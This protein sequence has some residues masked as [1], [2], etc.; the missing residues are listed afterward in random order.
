MKNT[1]N[2]DKFDV[3]TRREIEHF[4][5]CKESEFDKIGGQIA[6]DLRRLGGDFAF[7]NAA[8]YRQLE[9]KYRRAWTSKKKLAILDMMKCKWARKEK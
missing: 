1:M 4:I 7:L 8:Y 6:R 5:E 9:Q 3:I 2:L